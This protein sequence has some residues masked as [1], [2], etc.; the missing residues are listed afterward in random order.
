MVG[1]DVVFPELGEADDGG[2]DATM[3]DKVSF[4][5]LTIRARETYTLPSRNV[6]ARLSFVA[7]G[8]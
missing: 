6:K 8:T 1:E 2:N 4:H 7:S 3:K 5:P